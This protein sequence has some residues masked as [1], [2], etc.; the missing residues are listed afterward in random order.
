MTTDSSGR[1]F[2]KQEILGFF[3]QLKT[4]GKSIRKAHAV[5]AF[6]GWRIEAN[7]S[8]GDLGYEDEEA[9]REATEI[10]QS[11]FYKYKKIGSALRHLTLE[12]LEE[13]KPRNL[14]LLT[15]ITIEVWP[16]Y[17]WV[18]EAQKL[19][20]NDLAELITKRNHSAGSSREPMTTYRESV[21]YSSKEMI[22]AAVK[23]FQE[24]HDLATP[25]RALELLIADRY[26]RPSYL[27]ALITIR[28]RLGE[29]KVLLQSK[30]IEDTEVHDAVNDM[31][32]YAGEVYQEALAQARTTK[33]GPDQRERQRG[34]AAESGRP[35]GAQE[36]EVES[37]EGAA[38]AM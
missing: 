5:V 9:M 2:S 27:G 33:G 32:I 8:W 20:P 15:S 10:P 1:T 24:K 31:R 13:I 25:G 36:A 30:G 28:R 38:G 19:E 12:Q 17:D 22:D 16:E 11:T 6:C 35:N 18:G 7:E 21:P 29:L 14:E 34:S 4:V 23:S 26:D 37:V 3:Q